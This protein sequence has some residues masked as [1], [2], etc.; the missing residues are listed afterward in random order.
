MA[1]LHNPEAQKKAQKEIDSVL[2]NGH[3]PTF[4]DRESLPYVTALTMEVFR[5]AISSPIGNYYLPL[6]FT[7]FLVFTLYVFELA[8]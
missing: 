5:W 2:L 8:N 6:L 3:L 7:S 4:D 1:I